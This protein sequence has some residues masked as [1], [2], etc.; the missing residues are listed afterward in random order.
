MGTILES[1]LVALLRRDPRERLAAR[2]HRHR[3]IGS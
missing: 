1:E 3:H 2:R